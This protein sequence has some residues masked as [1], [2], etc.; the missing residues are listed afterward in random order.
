MPQS[1]AMSQKD[2]MEHYPG[3]DGRGWICDRCGEQIKVARDGWLQWMEVGQP[4][5]HKMRNLSLV[6]HRP[7]S[8]R[9]HGC[10]FDEQLEFRRD[11]GIV[12]DSG[13]DGYCGPD[14]LVELLSML[15]DYPASTTEILL[16]IQRIHVPGYERARR[17]ADR[18]ISEGALEPNLPKNFYSQNDIRAILDW[19]EQ[20]ESAF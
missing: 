12:G 13:L 1:K 9:S 15:T 5:E 8:P 4:G 16:M 10:Q 7:A 19:A 18:A 14:G 2:D 17:H 3:P 20:E 11:G 6:H